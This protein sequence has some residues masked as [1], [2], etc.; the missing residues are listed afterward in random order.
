M[1][2]YLQLFFLIAGFAT[3][4]CSCRLSREGMDKSHV[5]Y[6]RKNA[7]VIRELAEFSVNYTINRKDKSFR[8]DTLADLAMRKKFNRNGYG[9]IVMVQFGNNYNYNE[10]LP[11]S[12][13]VFEQWSLLRGIFGTIYDFTAKGKDCATDSSS[14]GETVF[15]KVTDRIYYR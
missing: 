15:L 4:L 13:V 8:T 9:G 1:Y 10:R 11:D 5:N 3:L 12:C 2:R 7:A 6:A 14:A